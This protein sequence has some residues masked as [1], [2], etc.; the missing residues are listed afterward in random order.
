[1]RPRRGW[2]GSRDRRPDR[3]T[4]TSMCCSR[5]GSATGARST[6]RCSASRWEGT[7]ARGGDRETIGD[8]RDRPLHGPGVRPGLPAVLSADREAERRGSPSG[9]ERQCRGDQP[10]ARPGLRRWRS[11]PASRCGERGRGRAARAR[12]PRRRHGPRGRGDHGRRRPCVFAVP[13]LQG[14]QGSGDERRCLR[15]PRPPGHAGCAGR[16]RGCR[17]ARP[18][19]GARLRPGRAYAAGRGPPAR[20]GAGS[21][22]GGRGGRGAGRRE[23][24]RQP[25]A[26]GARHR[27]SAGC[28]G[29]LVSGG[30]EEAGRRERPGAGH[31]AVLGAGSWGT[32]LALHLAR[33]GRQTILWARSE[34]AAEALRGA[35][36]NAGYLPGQRVPE[37]LKVTGHLREALRGAGIVLF[38]V[39]AQWSRPIY[40]A[41]SAHLEPSADLVIASKGIEE[42]RLLRLSEVLTQE[43]G[44]VA[45]RRAT[46]LSGPSF[47]VEVARGDPTAVVVASEDMRSAARVQEALSRAN[48]RVYRSSDLVGVELAGALKNVVAI[49]TGIAEGLGFGTNTR[50]ALI[51]RG[52]AEIARLGTRLG[53]RPATFAGLAGAGDL[54][55][56]CTGAL[57]RNRSVGL[58]GGRGRKLQDLL[59]GLRMIAEGAATSRAAVAP[60]RRH[61]TEMPIACQVHAVPC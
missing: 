51:T 17:G 3:S 11:R 54:V 30:R 48:L 47:A 18:G 13:A 9:R 28:G 33:S 25:R 15:G 57:S 23:T 22:R 41:A 5:A 53:G 55:L 24:P 31:A 34:R 14:R 26:A 21:D 20:R 4:C 16:F 37:A 38:V 56:T 12:D 29:S 42:D 59:A 19:G 8:R 49:A 35:R 60:G 1:M 45:G 27:A 43:A 46:V 6:R 2:I 50:A 32:A 58:E 36:E 52:M 40:R 39:P 61:R 7:G 44:G 10:G